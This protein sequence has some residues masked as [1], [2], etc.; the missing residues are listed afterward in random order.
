MNDWFKQNK[1]PDSEK[2]SEPAAEPKPK[3]KKVKKKVAKSVAANSMIA[4][5]KEVVKPRYF[6]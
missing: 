1:N 5:W 6:D 2:K 4:G 3:K